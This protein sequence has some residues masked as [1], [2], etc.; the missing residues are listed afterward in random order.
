MRRQQRGGAEPAIKADALVLIDQERRVTVG[1][2]VPGQRGEAGHGVFPD[3]G[4]HAAD[5]GLFHL[6]RHARRTEQVLHLRHAARGP[7]GRD[8]KALGHAGMA[9]KGTPLSGR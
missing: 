1:P 5:L 6:E 7:A 8:H 2:A 9:L 3:P 4:R